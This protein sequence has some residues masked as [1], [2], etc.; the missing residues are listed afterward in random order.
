MTIELGACLAGRVTLVTGAGRG[1]GEAAAILAGRRG[2]KVACLDR[3]AAAAE[4]CARRI[5]QQGGQALPI[6][7]DIARAA[8]LAA[9]TA[10]VVAS[11]GK[12][13]TLLAC[14]GI[15]PAEDL[16]EMTLEHWQRVVEVNLTGTVLTVQAAARVM[17]AAGGGRIVIVSSITGNRVGHPGLVA[18]SAAKAGINGLIRSAAVEL[19]P[20]GITVNG[21]EPGTVRTPGFVAS[22]AD[23]VAERIARQIPL[24][25][26]AQPE[27]I[28]GPMVFL[29]SD[30]AGYVTGQTLVVDGGQTLPELPATT[31]T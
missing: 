29:A 11:W 13:D 3:D 8:D 30:A 31:F 25:R 5:E 23:A 21:V 18:Y 26:I 6:A 14:A 9:A 16:L 12:L 27:E 28:A 4:P 10:R 22:G 7:A 20:L 1:I 17:R 19:A 24:G 2:A 15:H